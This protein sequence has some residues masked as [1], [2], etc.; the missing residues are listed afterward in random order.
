MKKRSLIKSLLKIPDEKNTLYW[1]IEKE[2]RWW[3]QLLSG[4]GFLLFFW[5]ISQR[6]ETAAALMIA[7]ILHEIGHYAVFRLSGIKTILM[8]LFPF[9]AM[10]APA[11]EEENQRSDTLPW[12]NMGWLLLIGALMNVLSMVVGWLLISNGVWV[13]FARELV[14]INLILTVFN[15]LPISNLDGGQFFKVIYASLDEREDRYFQGVVAFVYIFTLAIIFVPTFGNFVSFLFALWNN[16]FWIFFVF[17]LALGSAIKHKKD[18]AGHAN[19]SQAMTDGQVVIQVAV[20]SLMILG[21][22]GINSL[23]L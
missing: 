13:V 6:L 9:G 8:F 19:S 21:I 23:L 3:V 12:W 18:V 11:T 10:A 15:L 7:M 16:A 5:L 14:Y 1:I 22:F 17:I 2:N 20:Y 4:A